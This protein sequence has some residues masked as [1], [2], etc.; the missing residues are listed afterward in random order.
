MNYLRMKNIMLGYNLPKKFL[1]KTP[2]KSARIAA[3]G[4]NLAIILQ[5]TP[6][7]LDPE[8]TSTTSNGQG[9]EMGFALPSANYGFDLKVSF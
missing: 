7:G 5:N 3:V 4:R 9:L 6:R 2:F 8:A 1:R